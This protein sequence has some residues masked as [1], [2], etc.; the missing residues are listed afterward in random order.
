MVAMTVPA[1]LLSH[2]ELVYAPGE[3]ALVARAFELF[4]CTVH[5]GPTFLT[6]RAT[7]D[8]SFTENVWYAS[9]VTTEQ[10]A[11]ERA[12]RDTAVDHVDGVADGLAT[13]ATLLGD[14]P[15]RAPHFGIRYASLAALEDVVGALDGLDRVA[16]ELAGRL[17]VARR[18]DPGDPASLSDSVVQVFVRTSLFAAGLLTVGQVVEL[19][20]Y[21]R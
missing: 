13:Y 6:I 19:Q 4:G 12:L 5:D 15:Q 1:R 16:P 11:L 10:W 14:R 21:L 17:G 8:G 2:V 3:R 9:E 18:I 7:A 20:H